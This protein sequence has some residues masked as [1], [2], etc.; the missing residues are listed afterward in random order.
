MWRGAKN[1][2]SIDRGTTSTASCSVYLECT[3]GIGDM[4]LD[5]LSGVTV[6]LARGCKPGDVLVRTKFERADRRYDWPALVQSDIFRMAP[7]LAHP[8]HRGPWRVAGGL[9][10]SATL[11]TVTFPDV[12]WP[13]G[14]CGEHTI[15]RWMVGTP[16]VPADTTREGLLSIFRRVARSVWFTCDVIAL[17][18]DIGERTVIHARRGDKIREGY[19]SHAM[20]EHIYNATEKWLL[21]QRSQTVRA[22]T[23]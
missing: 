17:P 4:L 8:Q 11:V 3:T 23:T 21:A 2:T 15:S 9:H 14:S 18:V 19:S 22:H 10:D 20:L 5:T 13:N 16:V 12:R 6:A 7:T 1:L